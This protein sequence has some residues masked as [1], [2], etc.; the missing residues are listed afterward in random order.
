MGSPR[1]VDGYDVRVAT[2]EPIDQ[3]VAECP[4]EFP[5]STR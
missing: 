5:V 3:L 2:H 4:D 1:L